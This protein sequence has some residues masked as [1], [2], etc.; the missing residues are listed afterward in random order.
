MKL[1]LLS[2]PSKLTRPLFSVQIPILYRGDKARPPL[3]NYGYS[4]EI[5]GLAY[6][7]LCE[8]SSRLNQTQSSPHEL[9]MRFVPSGV[10]LTSG[11]LMTGYYADGMYSWMKARYGGGVGR[12]EFRLALT[13]VSPPSYS[14]T[15]TSRGNPLTDLGPRHAFT[16]RNGD[17]PMWTSDVRNRSGM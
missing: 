5:S 4:E 12:P 9:T 7:G 13:Q 14:Q 3:F 1:R 16:D 17:L 11:T 8:S 2:L 6:I 10:G 15:A